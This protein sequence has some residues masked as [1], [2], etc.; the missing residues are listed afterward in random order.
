MN[1]KT[2]IFSF[3]IFC[4]VTLLAQQP[5][6]KKKNDLFK[7]FHS[8]NS[9]QLLT[10]SSATSMSWH[11]V[12]G[13]S[14]GKFFG[15]IGTGMDY[16]YK[17][18]VPLFAEA[19]FDITGGNRKLQ[20]FANGGVHIPYG[21]INKKEPFKTGDFKTG[22][23]LAAGIDYYLPVKRNAFVIGLAYSQKQI[24]QMVDNTSWNPVLNELE[25][26]PIKELYSFNRYWMKVGYVF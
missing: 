13:F 2:G 24:T 15:G 22:R 20:L 6:V 3:L 16:Y 9:I 19:R 17:T 25:N 4:S 21:N 14:K 10:G 7:N 8:Y 23:L 11:S 1:Q 18:S 26:V 12:N 5:S